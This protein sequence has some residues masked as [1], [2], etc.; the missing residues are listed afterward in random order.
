M[1][2]KPRSPPSA[3]APSGV[4]AKLFSSLRMVFFGHLRVKRGEQGVT[5]TLGDKKSAP[6]R[7]RHAPT[8]QHSTRP[9]VHGTDDQPGADALAHMRG[10]LARVLDARANN[11]QALVHLALLEKHL[12]T[13]GLVVFDRMPVKLLAKAH[14]QLLL[15]SAA[16]E[17]LAQG[18]LMPALSQALARRKDEEIGV[19][20]NQRDPVGGRGVL[21]EEGSLSDF[22][23]AH[24]D[25]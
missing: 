3:N 13:S 5:I 14:E 12:K 18:E 17:E 7:E 15:V 25:S 19:G 23:D 11:R 20:N 10:E 16:H 2:T 6:S 24:R 22:L 1:A 8:T 21:V 9:G 4:F